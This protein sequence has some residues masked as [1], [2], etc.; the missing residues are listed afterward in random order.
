MIHLDAIQ[1]RYGK[2]VAVHDVSLLA[3]N[4]FVTGLL[5]PNGAGKTTA[6]RAIT[7]LI[8]PDAGRAMVD[9]LDVVGEAERGSGQA[10]CGSRE[11]RHL[12]SAERARARRLQ[13]R[14]ARA[15]SFRHRSTRAE[16]CSIN[17]A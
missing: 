8:R 16:R 1:K 10:R 6:L 9:G 12:R 15:Q 17:S 5:G 7:G 14:A 4:G 11:R 3:P 2:T 13:R